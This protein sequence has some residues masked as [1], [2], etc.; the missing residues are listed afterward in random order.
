MKRNSSFV[1]LAALSVCFVSGAQTESVFLE[2]P[3]LSILIILI[4]LS[5]LIL[6][7]FWSASIP[8][9][10]LFPFIHLDH[11]TWFGGFIA[12]SGL[13]NLV[14]LLIRIIFAWIDRIDSSDALI[15][16][17]TMIHYAC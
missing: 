13:I 12:F 11:V 16:L 7:S 15:I 8:F 10:Y 2:M 3:D 17:S 5:R 14:R 4:I 6:W 1:T 9:E